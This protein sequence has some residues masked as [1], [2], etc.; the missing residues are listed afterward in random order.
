MG[1]YMRKLER[2]NSILEVALVHRQNGL[3][4]FTVYKMA[5]WLGLSASTHLRKILMALVD[6]GALKVTSKKH[7]S[8]VDKAVFKLTDAALLSMM[9]F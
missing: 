7:R 8:N 9:L 3:K 4:T 6:R 2:E 1:K 5:K